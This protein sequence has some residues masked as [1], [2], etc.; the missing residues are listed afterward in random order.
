[1]SISTVAFLLQD[2]QAFSSFCYSGLK[3]MSVYNCTTSAQTLQWYIV[4]SLSDLRALSRTVNELFKYADDTTLLVPEHTDTSLEDKFRE[5]KR[6]TESDKMILNI[7]KTKE[8]V[9]HR[10]DPCLYIP[11]VPLSD[12][13][14]VKSVILHI[15]NTYWLSAASDCIYSNPC[16]DR[17]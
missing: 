6:R 15:L 8:I 3:H 17:N 16:V 10:P 11:H 14:R 4:T 12:I 1:M 13:E 9:F 7:L 2:V 5:L